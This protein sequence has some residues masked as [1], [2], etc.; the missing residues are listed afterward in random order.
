MISR[1]TKDSVEAL[2]A[3]RD[4]RPDATERSQKMFARK[5]GSH[6]AKDFTGA[7]GLRMVGCGEW[8]TRNAIE[9]HQLDSGMIE[10]DYLVIAIDGDDY[11]VFDTREALGYD[12]FI[13][14]AQGVAEAGEKLKQIHYNIRKQEKYRCEE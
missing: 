13:K 5:C 10:I 14:A 12:T 7:A 1:F 2:V 6:F 11:N 9:F 8:K 4:F 3:F